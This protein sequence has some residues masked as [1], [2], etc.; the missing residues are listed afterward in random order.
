MALRE[1]HDDIITALQNREPLLS[2]HLVKFEKPS[3]LNESGR[4]TDFVYLTDAPYDVNFNETGAQNGNNVYRAGG[5]VK[6]G[7]VQEAIEAKATKMSLTLSA[8]KLGATAIAQATMADTPSTLPASNGSGRGVQGLLTLDFDLFSAGFYVGDHIT[9]TRTDVDSSG[10]PLAFPKNTNFTGA[11]PTALTLQ[12][13][14]IRGDGKVIE[15]T[16]LEKEGIVAFNHECNIDYVNPEV[17]TLTAKNV[18]S[19]S[20]ESYVN[21]NVEIYRVFAN[22]KTGNVIGSPFIYFKGIIAQ[23][24]LNEKVDSNPTLVWSLTSHWG[25]FVRVQGRLTSDEFHRG[26]DS[27]GYSQRGAALKDAY[28]TDFG[29]EHADKSLNVLAKYTGTDS[30]MVSRRRGG[31]A[32]MM[33]GRKYS[34][35]YFEVERELDLRLN[36]ESKYIPIVYGVQKLETFPAFADI[37]VTPDTTPGESGSS[38]GGF[39]GGFTTMYSANVLCEG[40]ISALYDVFIDNETLVCKDEADRSVREIEGVTLGA[41]KKIGCIGSMERG[42]VAGGDFFNDISALAGGQI[43]SLNE[44]GSDLNIHS[45]INSDGE[46][47]VRLLTSQGPITIDEN[48]AYLGNTAAGVTAGNQKG[49]LH[50]RT[51]GPLPQA[52]DLKLTF[53]AG[54]DDQLANAT[55]MNKAAGRGTG[56]PSFLGQSYYEDSGKDASKYWGVSHRLLD[57]AYV[58]LEDK[59]SDADAQLPD[60]SYVVKGK[61]VNCFNYDGSYRN[62]SVDDSTS[63][64]HQGHF[65]LGDSVQITP[66]YRSF[67]SAAYYPATII[68]KWYL[69]DMDAEFDYRFRFKAGSLTINSAPGGNSL[70]MTGGVGTHNLETGDKVTYINTDNNP[71]S[72]LEN[73][74]TYFVVAAADSPGL[75]IGV[76]QIHLAETKEKALASPAVILPIATGSTP[77]SGPAPYFV[78]GNHLLQLTF[79]D[80][81]L[82]ND[83]L[84]RFSVTKG[85]NAFTCESETFGAGATIDTEATQYTARGYVH[86]IFPTL[87]SFSIPITRNVT[88]GQSMDSTTFVNDFGLAEEGGFTTVMGVSVPI[89]L[90]EHFESAVTAAQQAAIAASGGSLSASDFA[91]ALP[92]GDVY[93]YVFDFSNAPVIARNLI[94]AIKAAPNV[95][96]S[97]DFQIKREHIGGTVVNGVLQGGTTESASPLGGV[98]GWSGFTEFYDLTTDKLTIRG[99]QTDLDKLFGAVNA[100]RPAPGELAAD[101]VSQKT[102]VD[103]ATYSGSSIT[104]T[105]QFFQLLV[106]SSTDSTDATTLDGNSITF[107]KENVKDK[108]VGLAYPPTSAVATNGSTLNTFLSGPTASYDVLMLTEAM[109]G[110]EQGSTSNYFYGSEV[111]EGSK[112]PS[113]SDRRV[114][115]NPAI[116]LLDYLRSTT[117]GKGLSDDLLDLESFREA[118]RAC[119]QQSRV[120][121]MCNRNA[122]VDSNNAVVFPNV[123]VGDVYKYEEN[124]TLFFQGTLENEATVTYAPPGQTPLEYKEYTFKDVIGKLGRKYYSYTKYE[125]GEIVWTINGHA[126]VLASADLNT[127]GTI[128]A[129]NKPSS[130]L[131]QASALTGPLAGGTDRVGCI[132][133]QKVS[134]NPLS[135]QFIDLD[136]ALHYGN[137]GNPIVK[138]TTSTRSLGSGYDLYD[139]CEVKYWKYIGWEDRTQRFATRHQ[140][141][142]TIDTSAPLFDNVNQMLTQFNGILRYSNGKYQLDIKTK[143][144]DLTEFHGLEKINTDKIIGDIKITDKGITKTFNSVTTGYID[145]QNNFNSKNITFYNSIYKAE[146]KGI[147]RQGQYKAPGITNYYNNRM[148]IKQ[149]LDESRSGVTATFTGSPETYVLLPGNII[150]ITYERFNWQDKLFRIL[151]MSPRDDL[152]VEFTVIEHNDD[153]Y[154]LDDLSSD[155]V[156]GLYPEGPGFPEIRSVPPTGLTATNDKRGGIELNW[157]NSRNFRKETHIVEIWRSTNSNFSTAFPTFGTASD[158]ERPHKLSRANTTI[159][160]VIED[161][162]NTYYYWIRYNLPANPG[163]PGLELFS[164]FFPRRTQPGIAGVAGDNTGKVVTLLGPLVATYDALGNRTSAANFTYTARAFKFLDPRFKFTIDGVADA[165]YTAPTGGGTEITKTI[166]VPATVFTGTKDIKVEVQEGAS[167]GTIAEFALSLSAVQETQVQKRVQLFN[168]QNNVASTTFSVSDPAD[169]T[170]ANPTNNIPIGWE[171]TQ[172]SLTN[173]LDVVFMVERVFTTNGLTPQQNQWHPLNSSN[174]TVP[175]IVAERI[176]GGPGGPGPSGADAFVMDLDNENHTIA[177]DKNGTPISLAGANTNVTIFQGATDVSSQFVF[178]TPVSSNAG[179]QSNWNSATRVLTITSMANALSQGTISFRATKT[180]NNVVVT[181]LT[182]IFNISKVNAGEDGEDATIFRLVPDTNVINKNI[183]VTPNSFSPTSITLNARKIV[184]TTNSAVTS[185]DGVTISAF[186]DNAPNRFAFS[187]TGSL[188]VSQN[189]YGATTKQL[190]FELANTNSLSTIHD[191]ETVPILE[192]GEKGDAGLRTVTGYLYFKANPA[193]TTAPNPPSGNSYNFSSGTVTGVGINTTNPNVS[194]QW[195]NNPPILN[196]SLNENIWTLAYYGQEASSGATSIAVNYATSAVQYTNFTGVV[197]FSGGS[198]LVDQNNN[199]ISPVTSSQL[200]GTAGVTQ[201]TIDGANI[202][203]GTLRAHK[204]LGDVTETFSLQFGDQQAGL[205]STFTQNDTPPEKTFFIPKP[206]DADV[207]INGVS[208]NVARS[209]FGNMIVQTE[210]DTQY[211]I[212]QY[213]ELFLVDATFTGG[214]NYIQTATSSLDGFALSSGQQAFSGSDQ[215]YFALNGNQTEHFSTG[216]LIYTSSYRTTCTGVEFDGSVGTNGITK[217]YY[218]GAPS[219]AS[220]ALGVPTSHNWNTYGATWKLQAK[221]SAHDTLSGNS[222][223]QRNSLQSRIGGIFKASSPGICNIPLNFRLPKRLVLDD[224]KLKIQIRTVHHTTNSVHTNTNPS[225]P[226]SAAR[227]MTLRF[228]GGNFGYSK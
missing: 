204:I 15:V 152:L 106:Q 17:T 77:G 178:D 53:H 126:K 27:A 39:T 45:G 180:V 60:I 125:V 26:L 175:A 163:T 167:G 98:A 71:L 135:A 105:L 54:K 111:Y 228:L 181:T 29:F 32:G 183:N 83:G 121:V 85:A 214:N 68:D 88:L 216:G 112:F 28:V 46:M 96:K 2:Y 149:M 49:I 52:K 72:P 91:P 62:D 186:Q 212:R 16:N 87:K 6:I 117:Y 104:A 136:T 101:G 177:A 21:R 109:S 197:T 174:V 18:G 225:Q 206:S 207:T 8:V 5:I 11:A 31:I 47:V 59:I 202:S 79:L 151:S 215:Y 116:Q 172:P 25:D 143:A 128:K 182:A 108:T 227:N 124:G 191:E 166:T 200:D 19:L 211:I 159:D 113:N 131:P 42:D 92:N 122:I 23:G 146:D 100:V 224:V 222:T 84:K 61:L 123:S 102:V 1:I 14:R 56:A 41:S 193:V 130:A 198:T 195:L 218:Y 169:Q 115:T 201:T 154:I 161:G 205:S 114:S 133:L 40:P 50:E 147:S 148:N 157:K 93:E 70:N 132:A 210:S 48:G 33:G 144:K 188:T 220:G 76:N 190:R 145:P 22:P 107:V 43:T 82:I 30:R 213:V 140:M 189:Q 160:T 134:G 153:A 127:N 208:A 168:K 36:L 223:T 119:D 196:P 7:K 9:L 118:A 4:R 110:S 55:L 81:A 86:D 35:E 164:D 75:G 65:K 78:T 34:T 37:I 171:L 226:P 94:R 57:T 63:T 67:G 80:E 158:V 120:T 156:F 24:T 95:E 137:T 150:A 185:S 219:I 97:I 58:V 73:G 138:K 170:Y 129:A 38:S 179:L 90:L 173:N 3:N 209:L 142:Q 165:S 194:G 203:T 13:K 199:S 162:D 74:K 20:Y 12:I 10:N 64:R 221:A 99:Q 184:G 66:Y 139:A 176:D 192:E 187:N 89:A 141:N 69:L 103:T 217:I 51:I 155:A 44:F